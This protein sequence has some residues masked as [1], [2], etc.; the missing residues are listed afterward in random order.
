MIFLNQLSDNNL[1]NT[2]KPILADP[3]DYDAIMSEESSSAFL[4]QLPSQL[5]YVID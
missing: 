3:S 4:L 1:F 5:K 2:V